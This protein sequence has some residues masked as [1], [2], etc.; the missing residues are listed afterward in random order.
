MRIVVDDGEGC[1][2]RIAFAATPDNTEFW[3]AA[4]QEF[5]TVDRDGLPEEGWRI[6]GKLLTF[7]RKDMLALI[8]QAA[9]DGVLPELEWG[10]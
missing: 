3:V 8:D 2:E 4:R 6:V 7:E 1:T 9:A 10:A 5:S